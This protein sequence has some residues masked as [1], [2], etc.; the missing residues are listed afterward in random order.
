MPRRPRLAAGLIALS[1]LA[2]G[3]GDDDTSASPTASVANDAPDPTDVP[4]S[5][6][7]TTPT[8]DAAETLEGTLNLG[9]FPNVTHAPALVGVEQAHFASALGDGVELNILPFNAGT[10][11]TEALFG[12]AIDITFIGPNPAINAFAQSGGTAIRIISGSTSGGAYLVVDPE[13]TSVGQLEGRSLATPSL[14]NTQD[15][16]LRAWLKENGFETTP[17]GGGDVTI[18]P[19]SNATTLEAFV[20]GAI[21]GAWVPEPWAT[22]LIEEGGGTVLVDERDLWPETGGEYVTTHV[23]VRTAYLDEHPDIVT[24]FLEGL[25]QSIDAIAADPAA[26]QVAV[27]AQINAITDQDSNP[28]VIGASFENL[29]FTLDPVAASLKGSADD[30]VDVGLLDPVD[31]TGIYDLTLLNELVASRGGDPVEGLE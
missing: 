28:A 8:T 7:E 20:S 15:V 16:A 22:R 18:L 6:T 26:A 10:D 31:L 24:A 14:G 1:A 13:I 23:I 27:I 29:S 21:D 11:A 30:A 17:E 2:A 5:S 19:Q 9:L 25:I 3:C 12:E 4:A